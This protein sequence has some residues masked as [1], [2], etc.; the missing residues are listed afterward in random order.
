LLVGNRPLTVDIKIRRRL[1]PPRRA[2]DAGYRGTTTRLL[3]GRRPGAGASRGLPGSGLKS[4]PLA[5]KL[6]MAPTQSGFE[7]SQSDTSIHVNEYVVMELAARNPRAGTGGDRADRR[8]GGSDRQAWPRNLPGGGG[9][10]SHCPARTSREARTYMIVCDFAPCGSRISSCRTVR[11]AS[12][13]RF[14]AYHSGTPLVDDPNP[15]KHR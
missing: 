5:G 8:V 9:L 1:S 4:P 15:E 11:P 12:A 7:T 6:P 13:R 14:A 3:S 2:T 10:A